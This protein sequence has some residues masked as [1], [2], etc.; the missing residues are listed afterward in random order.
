MKKNLI[1]LLMVVLV[2]S[3]SFASGVVSDKV[4]ND[5]YNISYQL[6]PDHVFE[7]EYYRQVIPAEFCEPFLYY[8]QDFPE[9]SL[10]FYCIM[11]HESGNFRYFKNTNRNGTIDLGPSQLN[12]ANLENLDFVKAFAPKDNYFIY[13]MN[14]YYMVL[15]IN[16]YYDL[17]KRLGEEFAFFAY[18]GGDRAA[19][20]VR[21][22]NKSSRYASLIKA[23]KSYDES[24]RELIEK[25][26]ANMAAFVAKLRGEFV[27][28]LCEIYNTRFGDSSIRGD[29]RVAEDFYKFSNN[30][31]T[32]YIRR[33]DLA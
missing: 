21:E 26:K 15:T 3:T 1:K 18:N 6:K 9:I 28:G 12:S 2:V 8:T 13:S 23:V 33:E 14:C 17:Y 7:E 25:H 22:N 10:N 5:L 24:V 32:Y 27:D 11:V 20:L 30:R 4:R 29:I 16:Y 19:R 31:V